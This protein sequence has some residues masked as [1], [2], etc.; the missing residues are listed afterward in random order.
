MSHALLP[1]CTDEELVHETR[2]SKRVL[3]EHVGMPVRSFCYP[4]GDCDARVVAAVE[5]AGYRQAVTTRDGPNRSVSKRFELS[6]VD[7]QSKHLRGARGALSPTQLAWRISAL[8]PTAV[9]SALR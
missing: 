9:K 5:R 1:Q 4:N 6:R 7:L 2:E 3:E 8:H